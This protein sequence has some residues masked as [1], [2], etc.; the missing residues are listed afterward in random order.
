[1]QLLEFKVT[2]IAS[3]FGV[4]QVEREEPGNKDGIKARIF[5]SCVLLFFTSSEI[6]KKLSQWE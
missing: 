2:T 6:W 3:K 5:H 4:S 1:M